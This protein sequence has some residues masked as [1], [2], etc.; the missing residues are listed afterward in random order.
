MSRRSA[1]PLLVALGA[2]AAVI[3]PYLA[4]GGGSYAPTPV[5][6]PCVRREWRDPGGLQA[7]LE[8]V[9]LSGLDGAACDLGVSREELVLALADE[10]SVDKFAAEHGITRADAERAVDEGIDRAIADAEQADALP[11]FVGSLLR[12]FLDAV[13]PWLVLDTL[14]N[15]R[16]VLP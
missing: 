5:A 4:L 2:V 1:L 13:P 10:A 7:V 14:E 6:D 12:R 8:Q 11:D 16:G 3:V 15:L 9:V